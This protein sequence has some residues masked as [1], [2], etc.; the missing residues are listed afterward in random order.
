M[1]AIITGTHTPIFQP[2]YVSS[3]IM[4]LLNLFQWESAGQLQACASPSQALIAGLMWHVLT[5]LM[6]LRAAVAA[7]ARPSAAP[8]CRITGH[9]SGTIHG[10]KDSAGTHDDVN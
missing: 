3:V 2:H 7:A 6:G 1:Y 8:T 4:H 9:C 10:V 5:R